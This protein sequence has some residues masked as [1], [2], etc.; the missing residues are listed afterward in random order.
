MSLAVGKA[1]WWA[2]SADRQA[3]NEGRWWGCS[4]RPSPVS[5]VGFAE[6]TARVTTRSSTLLMTM[7]MVEDEDGAR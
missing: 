1:A 5:L 6:A 4:F 3:A 7:M 2:S